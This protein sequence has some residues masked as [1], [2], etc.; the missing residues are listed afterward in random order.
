MTEIASRARTGR[1][2]HCRTPLAVLAGFFVIAAST[3]CSGS[4]ELTRSR[5]D[6]LVRESVDFRRPITIPLP[7]KR[8]Q[9]TQ[10]RSLNESEE[11]ARERAIDDYVRAHV[12][13][14]VFRHLGLIDFRAALVERPSPEHEWWRFSVEPVLTEAGE[15]EAAEESEGKGRK[16]I[17]ISRPDLIELTGLATPAAGAARAEFTWKEVPTPA[18]EA[19][20]PTTD[21]YRGL[22]EWIRR[23][24]AGPASGMG[25]G[26]ERK[27]DVPRKG[28]ALLQLY[29][30]GWRVQ[31]I[32]F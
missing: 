4:R 18:G 9:P 28:T 14:A 11:V 16:G 29:D 32:Q 12:E 7:G 8:E 26:L 25:K 10:A 31:H 21:A 17:V 22:P 3:N 30:D 19:F 2:F 24:M 1:S 6:N 23:G 27:Y 20:D 13:M 5:A 15:R